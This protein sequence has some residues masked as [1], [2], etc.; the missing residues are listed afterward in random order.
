MSRVQLKAIGLEFEEGGNTIWVHG[1]CGTI[2]RIQC[3]GRIS[4]KGCEA[5]SAHA[6]L[7]VEGDVCFCV[8]GDLL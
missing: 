4:V 1:A 8:P 5:P 7:R 3:S 2:L 6:D